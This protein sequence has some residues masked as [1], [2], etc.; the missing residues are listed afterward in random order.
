M[1][2]R[3]DKQKSSSK[4]FGK[5]LT[6][7][8]ENKHVSNSKLAEILG[9]KSQAISGYRSGSREPDIDSLITI[10][11]HLETSIDYLTGRVDDP[12]PSFE[13]VKMAEYTGL[14]SDA[15]ERLHDWIS[16]DHPF[17]DSEKWVILL[18]KMIETDYGNH[19]LYGMDS[20]NEP[21]KHYIV[22]AFWDYLS[23]VFSVIN[24]YQ[25]KIDSET[26]RP[27]FNTIGVYGDNS[28]F[29]GGRNGLINLTSELFEK[30]AFEVFC[31][32]IK[33]FAEVYRA[34]IFDELMEE[35]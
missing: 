25:A 7:L 6:E 12:N 14:S 28:L 30:A 11:R 9:V 29:I 20:F 19:D 13:I 35:I 23:S 32:Q 2:G 5:R 18:S 34:E 17:R 15:I 33:N 27:H 1:Q 3:K 31:D 10:A 16:K 24:L 21:S 8:M 4:A 22:S 26:G